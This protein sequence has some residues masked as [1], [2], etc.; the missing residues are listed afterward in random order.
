MTTLDLQPAEYYV[1]DI[2]PCYF[3]EIECYIRTS[4]WMYMCVCVCA[5]VGVYMC[6]GVC[7]CVHLWVCACVRVYMS[8]CVHV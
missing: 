4:V 3:L 8:G 2:N 6:G 1:K 7:G 5:S